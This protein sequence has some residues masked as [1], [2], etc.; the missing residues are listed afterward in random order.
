VL[1]AVSSIVVPLTQHELFHSSKTSSANNTTNKLAAPR[2]K[3]LASLGILRANLNVDEISIVVQS[4]EFGDVRPVIRKVIHQY[5]QLII[6]RGPASH[7]VAIKRRFLT[8]QLRK[9]GINSKL[10]DDALADLSDSHTHYFKQQV[11]MT[12]AEN[13]SRY[14][15]NVLHWIGL[16]IDSYE[17]HMKVSN[18]STIDDPYIQRSPIIFIDLVGIHISQY[19]YMYDRRLSLNIEEVLVGDDEYHPIIHCYCDNMGYFDCLSVYSKNLG[20]NINSQKQPNSNKKNEFVATNRKRFSSKKSK[21]PDIEDLAMQIEA[22]SIAA[23]SAVGFT[24]TEQDSAYGWAEGGNHVGVLYR[25]PSSQYYNARVANSVVNVKNIECVLSPIG[26]PKIVAQ[27]LPAVSKIVDNIMAILLRMR[28]YFLHDSVVRNKNNDI[29]LKKSGMNSLLFVSPLSAVDSKNTYVIIPKTSYT[30]RLSI[31]FLNFV[32]SLD[33]CMYLAQCNITEVSAM[34]DEQSQPSK[35][36]QKQS[37]S[38]SSSSDNTSSIVWIRGGSMEMY[39]L[40]MCGNKHPLVVWKEHNNVQHMLSAKVIL[41]S[42]QCDIVVDF[43]GF[44]CCLLYRFYLEMELFIKNH[45]ISPLNDSLSQFQNDSTVLLSDQGII[46]DSSF[47]VDDD[48]SVF[49]NSSDDDSD[50]G[51]SSDEE[52]SLDNPTNYFSN[53]NGTHSSIDRSAFGASAVQTSAHTTTPIRTNTKSPLSRRGLQSASAA[54]SPKIISP[55][56]KPKSSKKKKK[57]KYNWVMQFI[58]VTL[59]LP[60]NSTSDDLAALRVN[61]VIISEKKVTESWEAPKDKHVLVVDESEAYYF[62]LKSNSWRW[63]DKHSR[64]FSHVISTPKSSDSNKSYTR[65]LLRG[66]SSVILEDDNEEDDDDENIFVEANCGPQTDME[67]SESKYRTLQS[68]YSDNELHGFKSAKTSRSRVSLD[69]E[70][71]SD[72]FDTV[73]ERS[74]D[75]Y[76]DAF[77]VDTPS[78]SSQGFTSPGYRDLLKSSIVSEINTKIPKLVDMSFQIEEES[79]S[80][81]EE[82]DTDGNAATLCTRYSVEM[83]GAVLF[84]SLSSNALDTSQPNSIDTI[85]TE[86]RKFVEV[87][88]DTPVYAIN[89]ASLS[90]SYWSQQK[91]VSL[92]HNPTNM[93]VVVD[94][95]QELMRMLFSETEN[96]S[97]FEVQAS[98]AELYVLLSVYYDNLNETAMYFDSVNDSKN[99][100]NSAENVPPKSYGFYPEYGTK[101]YIEYIKRRAPTFELLFMR[102]KLVLTCSLSPPNYFNRPLYSYE[103]FDDF[104]VNRDCEPFCEITMEWLSIYCKSDFEIMQFALGLGKGSIT[105]LRKNAVNNVVLNLY[106]RPL[107]S[108]ESRSFCTHGYSDFDF[109]CNLSPLSIKVPTDIPLKITYFSVGSSWGSCN[110]GSD[111]PDFDMKNLD[112]VWLI[113]DYFSMYFRFPQF[114]N[115]SIIAYGYTNASSWPYGGVDTRVF[116]TRPHVQICEASPNNR[117]QTLAIEAETGLYFRYIYDSFGSIRYECHIHGLCLVLMKSYLSPN[118]SRGLRGTAGSGRGVRTIVEEVSVQFSYH[119]NK[120]ENRLDVLASISP[121]AESSVLVGG[122]KRVFSKDSRKE[123]GGVNSRVDYSTMNMSSRDRGTES[124]TNIPF[125]KENSVHYQ[126]DDSKEFANEDLSKPQHNKQ[127]T[128]HISQINKARYTDF[129]EDSLALHALKL[130]AAKLLTP[131]PETTRSFPKSCCTV[132]TSIEDLIFIEDLLYKFIDLQSEPYFS[133]LFNVK[134]QVIF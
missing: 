41:Q 112:L 35:P 68:S 99:S 111:S 63:S 107:N 67:F 89:N 32:L 60:R 3:N 4:E 64:F 52:F 42:N 121:L 44:R 104:D 123:D 1:S 97:S 109:G 100:F 16:I 130:P 61:K 9:M 27:L 19:Q 102:S 21:A 49:G 119:F 131:I 33:K 110:I 28:V 56:K 75:E 10:I 93:L 81:E 125:A 116:I 96:K 127:S 74:D 79:S 25:K 124:V 6:D 43:I 7:N 29:I 62:D 83:E 20:P 31:S 114:G 76:V 85:Q 82:E 36:S 77:D 45:I 69:Y 101:E 11:N 95:I 15:D 65:R 78:Y 108:A 134:R 5:E 39:D 47:L 72:S 70:N 22:N 24:Y 2:I 23:Y 12:N 122:S 48:N 106:Q 54:K 115:P 58:N 51:L 18:S 38:Q 55:N 133:S 84:C 17:A 103:L 59:V 113:S 118:A 105:D 8:H 66:M 80:D 117:S 88:H 129:D 13:R 91:W 53:A 57:Y 71:S 90:N 126:H 30:Y 50:N 37:K 92:M 34:M 73:S 120:P 46:F 132:I 26:I 98:M 87:K 94:Y 128:H 14:H 40:S 86:Y